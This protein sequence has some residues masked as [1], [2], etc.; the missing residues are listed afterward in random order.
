MAEYKGIEYFS[1][2]EYRK[3]Y[4]LICEL[5]MPKHESD[6][7]MCTIILGGQPGSGK[8]T[9]YSTI[10]DVNDFVIINGD[11]F[12]KFHP[13]F[14]R[15]TRTDPE[16]FAER[17]QSFS[18]RIVEQLI[19]D[20]SEKGINMVIEGTLRTADAPINTCEELKRA[21]YNTKLCVI[22]CD[23]LLAWNST[24]SR[25]KEAIRSGNVVRL[26]PLDV[27]D[28]TVKNI[29][30]NLKR[31][32]QQKCFDKIS[33]FN[34]FSDELYNSSKNVDR[35]GWEI[36]KNELNLDNWEEQYEQIEKEFIATK[37]ELLN[38]QLESLSEISRGN[39]E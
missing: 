19:K 27:Y 11:D 39:D 5:V 34:R 36:L 1:E 32:E 24:I 31:I 7:N 12:R 20:C 22:A 16:H 30:N 23:A 13:R 2:D 4:K 26:V 18:N 10:E 35:G 28:Y 17:T 9:Y 38:N 14:E 8:S 6:N 15:I 33:I 21:G 29:C 37:I 3:S 25:A